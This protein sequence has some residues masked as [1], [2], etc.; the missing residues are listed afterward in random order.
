MRNFLIWWFVN[1]ISLFV[2]AAILPGVHVS[3]GIGTLLIVAL[4][5][6]II[7]ALLRPILY[8]ASCGLIVLTLGLIIPVLNAL[9]L[10]LADDVAGDRLTIDSLGWAILAAIIMGILN[11]FLNSFFKEKDKEEPYVIQSR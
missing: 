10:L 6:G 5:I 11:W 1:S 7:N 8:I 3:G 4:I 2:V 9:L